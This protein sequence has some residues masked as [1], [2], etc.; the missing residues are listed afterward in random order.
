LHLVLI[1]LEGLLVAVLKRDAAVWRTIYAPLVP[2]LWRA[3][4]ELFCLRREIQ[5][6]R[7]ISL[8]KWFAVFV[9]L[10]YKLVMLIKHGLPNIR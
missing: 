10:P 7:R 8:V 2:A 5:H 3:R 1:N 9:V 6:A 4:D